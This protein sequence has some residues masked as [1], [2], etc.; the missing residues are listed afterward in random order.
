MSARFRLTFDTVQAKLLTFFLLVAIPVGAI[1][2]TIAVVTYRDDIRT[3]E[4]TQAQTVGNFVVRMRIWYVGVLRG[5]MISASEAAA[6]ASCDAI[7]KANVGQLD[8]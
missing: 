5:L 6:G 2:S 4:A 3:I 8:G 7:G 1:T